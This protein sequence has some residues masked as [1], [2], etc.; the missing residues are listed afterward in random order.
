MFLIASFV[1]EQFKDGQ[2]SIRSI[3]MRVQYFD[4]TGLVFLDVESR[5]IPI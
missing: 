2:Q 1:P 3:M 5:I 4:H